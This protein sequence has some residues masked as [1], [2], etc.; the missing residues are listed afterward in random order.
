[1]ECLL[2]PGSAEL[3]DGR[4]VDVH[5][6]GG[7]TDDPWKLE[8]P[9]R[10]HQF[11]MRID[12]DSEPPALICTV[13]VNSFGYQLR[14]VSDLHQM[15]L[16][17]GDWVALGIKDEKG[18]PA[19]GTVEAWARSSDNPVGGWYGLKPGWRGRFA[20]YV[21]PLLEYFGLAELEHNVTGNRMKGIFPANGP[22][23]ISE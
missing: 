17:R 4:L 1:V 5:S 18:T 8:T 10:V 3:D 23:T 6:G 14:C 2:G 7:T 21:P 11:R 22:L 16:A 15:L 12:P 20:T 9:D 19:D 13:G